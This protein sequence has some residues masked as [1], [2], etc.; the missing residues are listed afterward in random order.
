MVAI[1][2]HGIP[3]AACD[4][5]PLGFA[6]TYGVGPQYVV[7]DRATMEVVD[8]GFQHR[9]ELLRAS[10]SSVDA[11]PFLHPGLEHVAGTLIS[12]ADVANCPYPLGH[13]FMLFPNPHAAPRYS[14][15][16]LPVG[17]EWRLS[18]LAEGGYE[19]VEV[20]EHSKCTPILRLFHAT[21]Q[22]NARRILATGFADHSED[23]Y[24][25]RRYSGVW[26][27]EVPLYELEPVILLV[28]VPDDLGRQYEIPGDHGY[29]RWLIPAE[30]I[31]RHGTAVEFRRKP[32]RLT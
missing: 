1:N 28:S 4:A 29:R 23:L 24:Q 8:S 32:A 11:A 10:G 27:A 26:L 21:T 20:I 7:F 30:I 3:N 2:V 9:P 25:G 17:R 14:E 19:I 6:A 5:E 31:N 18:A 13:E 16:Q 15:R 12:G 22:E